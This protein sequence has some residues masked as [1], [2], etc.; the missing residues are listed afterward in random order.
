MGL[1]PIRHKATVFETASSTSCAHPQISPR[2][3]RG[4][5]KILVISLYNL[6]LKQFLIYGGHTVPTASRTYTDGIRTRN[7]ML[8]N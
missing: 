1:A 8:D 4:V 2:L 5:T 3:F 6:E 7:I